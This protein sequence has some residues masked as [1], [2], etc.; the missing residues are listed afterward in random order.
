[1]GQGRGKSIC[2]ALPAAI[3]GENSKQRGETPGQQK[4]RSERE[5]RTQTKRLPRG[6]GGRT[7]V[8]KLVEL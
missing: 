7:K 1:M 8:P 5:D 4:R 2:P 6:L 3:P